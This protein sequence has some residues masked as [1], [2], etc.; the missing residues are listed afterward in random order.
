MY[1]S[2]MIIFALENIRSVYN[3][4]SIFRTGEGFGL[5]D[6][7]LIGITPTPLDKKGEKRKDFIKT[8][9]GSE[10]SVSWEYFETSDELLKKYPDH[11]ILS[12][13]MNN[14]SED[15]AQM[16]EHI[17]KNKNYI[18][19][20]GSEVNGVSPEVLEKSNHIYH[21]PMHGLKES[22]NVSIAAGICMYLLKN[23]Q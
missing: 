19:F 2:E 17:S 23:I 5:G 20:L 13:E 15:I 9:L 7:A 22:F 11:E 4:G 10:D 16:T 1:N 14:Y 18:I 6:F 8:A 3:V 21:I 12:I